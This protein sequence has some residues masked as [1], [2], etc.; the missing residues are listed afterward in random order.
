MFRD[1]AHHRRSVRMA[2]RNALPAQLVPVGLALVDRTLLH[3]KPQV[4]AIHRALDSLKASL[5]TGSVERRA[6]EWIS[7]RTPHALGT[8]IARH[9]NAIPEHDNAARPLG[10]AA[11]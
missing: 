3:P 8:Y 7:A 5:P 2:P 9:P 1:P 10:D 4:A 6:A 11:S